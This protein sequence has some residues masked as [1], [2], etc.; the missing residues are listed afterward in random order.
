MKDVR[1]AGGGAEDNKS[2]LAFRQPPLFG[3]LPCWRLQMQKV[4]ILP[5]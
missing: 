3:L 2:P 1:G 5:M 4:D